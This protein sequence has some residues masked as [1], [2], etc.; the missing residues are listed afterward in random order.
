MHLYICWKMSAPIWELMY[1]KVSWMHLT[2]CAAKCVT[3]MWERKAMPPM[4]SEFW[5][6][7]WLQ[8][9]LL[10]FSWLF[11]T[12]YIRAS[13]LWSLVC[14]ALWYCD[15][16][17]QHRVSKGGDSGNDPQLKWRVLNTD[18]P[19]WFSHF[20]PEPGLD[21]RHPR[22]STT[23]S[24]SACTGWSS[25]AITCAGCMA[26]GWWKS[27]SGVGQPARV[28]AAGAGSIRASGTIT[29]WGTAQD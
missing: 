22:P 6:T 12:A 29:C 19:R 26:A 13:D 18:S 14:S 11:S 5:A 15:S 24:L 8:E 4:H 2:N 1:L 16:G 7:Q 27:P 20:L 3:V 17:W 10:S 25:L 21:F 28:A 23:A 9:P